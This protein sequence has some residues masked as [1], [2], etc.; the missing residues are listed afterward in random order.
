MSRSYD[1]AE[2]IKQGN[3]KPTIKIDG[4][5]EY[6]VNT[7]K[8]TALAIK[9]FSEDKSKDDFD[10]LDFIVEAALGKEA[11]EYINSLDLTM[12]AI[13]IVINAIMAAIGGISLEEAENEAKKAQKK[14]RK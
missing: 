8:N 4:D 14:F 5:H 12:E 9:A 10:Q 3:K 1:I 13:T 7:S 6:E 2:K 11:K